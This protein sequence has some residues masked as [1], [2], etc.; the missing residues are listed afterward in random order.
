MPGHK[1]DDQFTDDESQ[2]RLQKILRG[3]FSGPPTPLK[4]VPTRHGNK[5]AEPKLSRVRASRKPRKA[6]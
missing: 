4:A 5:R 3:A 1:H 6:T 2:Q